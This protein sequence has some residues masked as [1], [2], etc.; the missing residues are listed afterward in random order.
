MCRHISFKT[1]KMKPLTSE[2]NL[3]REC[4]EAVE[5]NDDVAGFGLV[6]RGG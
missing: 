5:E 1:F 2:D 4:A 3:C 6:A